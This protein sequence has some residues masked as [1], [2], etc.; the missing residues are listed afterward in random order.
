MNPKIKIE[1]PKEQPEGPDG[2]EGDKSSSS[3]DG[4]NFI[5][6]I[7]D[8]VLAKKPPGFSVIEHYKSRLDLKIDH[9][10]FY[11]IFLAYVLIVDAVYLSIVAIVIGSLMVVILLTFAHG[12]GIFDWF[13]GIL[14][15]LHL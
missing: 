12:V 10:I 3:H 4:F 15:K 14:V 6:W 7:F 13:P 11:R 2:L 5:K 1:P 9:P 8:F